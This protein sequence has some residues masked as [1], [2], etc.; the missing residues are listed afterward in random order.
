MKNKWPRWIRIGLLSVAAAFVLL[1]IGKQFEFIPIC[2]A[3][4]LGVLAP[5]MTIMNLNVSIYV[6]Y[7]VVAIWWF[8]IGAVL[9]TLVPKTDIIAVIWLAILFSEAWIFY[10]VLKV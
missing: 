10:M 9:G 4:V 3:F 2:R 8:L 6:T 7:A 5:T 1:I